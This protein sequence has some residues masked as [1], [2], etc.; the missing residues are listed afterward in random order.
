[1]SAWTCVEIDGVFYESIR[2]AQRELPH[3][4]KTV[5]ER[6]LSNDWLNYRFTPYRVAFTKKRC[7]ICGITKSVD[8]FYKKSSNKDG[9]RTDC[10]QC[11]REYS[12]EYGDMHSE[13]RKD[14]CK[15]WYNNNTEH[16]KEYNKSQEVKDRNNE[17]ARQKR[18][19]NIMFKLNS[20]MGCAIRRSLKG[21]KNG[22]HWEDLVDYDLEEL[23]AHLEKQFLPG[24][25]WENHGTGEGMWHIDHIIPLYWFVFKSYK[26]KGFKKAWA[27]ENLRPMWGA[28]NIRKGNKLFYS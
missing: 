23:M 25:T 19:N 16:I 12:K 18:K 24:M 14:S 17:W 13:W 3:T 1:M 22:V 5:K 15:K 11:C 27:L 10:K 20:V 4:W 8:E 7:S 6:C 26:D 9:L 21:K 2:L 28:E